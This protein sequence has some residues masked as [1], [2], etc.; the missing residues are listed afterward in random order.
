MDDVKTRTENAT[1]RFLRKNEQGVDQP[2]AQGVLVPGGFIFTAAHC[3]NWEVTDA[4]MALGDR[5]I[6]KIRARNGSVYK[7]GPCAVEPVLDIAA[8]AALDGQV[9]FHECEAFERFCEET[10]PVPLSTDNF[11]DGVPV[12]I[13]VLTHTGAW[14]S[15]RASRYGYGWLLAGNI[16]VEFDASIQG[17]TSGSPVIDDNG[18]LV[19]VISPRAEWTIN[20]RTGSY[21]DLTWLCRYGC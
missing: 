3:I 10:E 2:V 16:W 15:G 18:L 20:I 13:R 8:L 19:G 9:F 14:V 7:V 5:Y 6:E 1:V 12:P 11:Q 17:G 4:A 21:P